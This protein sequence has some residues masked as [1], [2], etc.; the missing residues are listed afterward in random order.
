M[1]SCVRGRHQLF[2]SLD[3]HL[4]RG[5]ERVERRV[6]CITFI[7]DTPYLEKMRCLEHLLFAEGVKVELIEPQK[8]MLEPYQP[9]VAVTPVQLLQRIGAFM[10][11]MSFSSIVMS[12]NLEYGGLDQ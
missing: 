8:F 9:L 12:L 3:Q 2:K 11:K 4:D 7:G 5:Y 10:K 6:R 1:L